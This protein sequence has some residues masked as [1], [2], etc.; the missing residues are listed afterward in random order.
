MLEV[1]A[2]VYSE[3]PCRTGAGFFE[4]VRNIA[5]ATGCRNL[6]LESRGP[7]TRCLPQAVRFQMVPFPLFSSVCAQHPPGQPSCYETS[8]LDRRCVLPYHSEW[9]E[10]VMRWRSSILSYPEKCTGSCPNRLAPCEY[11]WLY[12]R[13]NSPLSALSWTPRAARDQ[14]RFGTRMLLPGR[15]GRATEEA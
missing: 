3:P 2:K 1:P 7:P 10:Y 12:D 9:P 6:A 4:R 8:H 14:P 5:A 15:H 13:Q 11:G